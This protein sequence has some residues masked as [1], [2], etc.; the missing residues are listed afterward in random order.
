MLCSGSQLEE[1]NIH[2]CNNSIALCRVV[3]VTV[4]NTSESF[5]THE[6]LCPFGI[7]AA[8][9]RSRSSGLLCLVFWYQHFGG[10]RWYPNI[11]LHGVTTQKTTAWILISVK[12]KSL[13]TGQV[14][15]KFHRTVLQQYTRV[16][17]KVSG[18]TAWSENC[19]WYSSLSLSLSATR[20][21]FIAIL[22]VIQASASITLR[23]AFQR[24]SPKVGVYFVIDSVRKLLDKRSYLCY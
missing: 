24:V 2:S 6:L 1:I 3:M 20:C 9:F 23:V 12:L 10:P 14:Y 13:A 15:F 18:L 21:S 22:W 19:K 11:S 17:P 5:L 8:E 4:V 7:H 16:Y